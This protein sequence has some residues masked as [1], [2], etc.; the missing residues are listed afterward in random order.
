M[1]SHP[2][3]YLE[4]LSP[5]KLSRILDGSLWLLEKTGLQVLDEKLWELVKAKAGEGVFPGEDGRLRLKPE[6]A[7]A[8]IAKA[9]AEWKHLAR[10]KGDS[11][12]FGGRNLCVAPGYGSVFMADAQGRRREATFNDYVRLTRLSQASPMIDLCSAISVEPSDVPLEK[13]PET[14]TAALLLNSDKPIMGAVTGAEGAAKS[15]A[16]AEIVLGDITDKPWLL[17]LI[18][19]NSPLRLDER[20]GGALRVYLEKGQPVIFTPGATMGV[21]GPATVAGNMAQSYA[22]LIGATALCQIVKPGHPVIV[23]NG[24]FGGNLHTGSPG[25]GRPENSLAS[26]VGGQ[27]ARKLKLPYRCS[28]AVTSS[29]IPDGRAQLEHAVTAAGAWAG[30][31]NLALQAAGILDSI[32]AMNLEQFVIDLEMW[33]YYERLS[34]PIEIDDELLALELIAEA[35]ASYMASPHTLKH[36]KR[37]IYEPIFG[38]PQK[39]ESIR[40]IGEL[41]RERLAKIESVSPDIEPI[42]PGALSALKQFLI[43]ND[44]SFAAFV[45]KHFPK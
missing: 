33:G 21:T 17:G 1:L 34:R 41:A 36:F 6:A 12:T 16:A 7:M 29:M 25:Y 35:P 15:F 38:K 18:N 5:E 20:M 22:D 2:E 27:I 45:N 10:K 32:N 14:M 28:A 30:G 3:N 13:R 8:L 26:I 31:A 44:P 42:D 37:E 4:K 24:G 11:V 43:G 39:P 40:E 23:G 19:I 9:P